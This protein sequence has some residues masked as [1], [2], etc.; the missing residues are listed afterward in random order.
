MSAPTAR[1]STWRST[2]RTASLRSDSTA[3]ASTLSEARIRPSAASTRPL[4]SPSLTGGSS[5]RK[6]AIQTAA[7]PTRRGAQTGSAIRSGC[8]CS[9]STR[10]TASTP[11]AAHGW[12]RCRSS[13][14][15]SPTWS[16]AASPPRTSTC[17]WPTSRGTRS[18]SSPSL[19]CASGREA[20]KEP[21]PEGGGGGSAALL[22]G[23]RKGLV[24]AV[25]WSGACGRHTTTA[26]GTPASMPDCYVQFARVRR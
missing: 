9:Q 19:G 20:G 8:A 23:S 25:S 10:G 17:T 2:R 6:A 13:T 14:R 5:S 22:G 11:A 7:R 4:A 21:P 18:T 1:A 16:H 12:C 26:C 15:A 3:L 24:S